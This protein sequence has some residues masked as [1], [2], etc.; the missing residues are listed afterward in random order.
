M[1][2]TQV[3]SGSVVLLAILGLAAWAGET[4]PLP[5]P[6][7]AP[8][9]G[10]V[11]RENYYDAKRFRPRL[12]VERA[13]R[14]LEQSEV[15]VDTTWAGDQIVLNLRGNRRSVPAA[16]PGTD[17]AAAMR[18]IESVRLAV[19]AGLDVPPKRLRELAYTLANGALSTLDPHTV[20]WPP[21]AAREWSED[22][23]Q[24]QFYGIGAFLNQEEG[25]IS[26]Q[27]VMAGLPAE[28]AGV[29]DGD[30]ILAIDGEKT[31][32]LTLEQ[33]VR[34]I[35]GPKGTTVNL[36]L[37]RKGVKAPVELPI[38]RDLVKVI[39]M[40]GCRD[41]GVGYVRMDEFNANT[42]HD[43]FRTLRELEQ[44]ASGAEPA[45]PLKALVL[46]LRFN[47]GGLL[48]QAKLIGGFFLGRGQEIVRTTTVDGEEEKFTNSARRFVVAPVMVLTSAGT[49]S[50][51]EIVSG[52]LQRNERAVIAGEPT[53]GKGSVQN[54]RELRDASRLKL[55]IQEYLL[56]GGVS[57]QDVGV[58]PDL[59]LPRHGVRQDGSVDLREFAYERER[60]NEFALGGRNTYRHEASAELGWLD[61]WLDREARRKHTISAREFVP[62][63][64]AQLAIDLLK[65][66]SAAEDWTAA[67]AKALD[68][69][70]QRAFLL[71][72]LK[73]PV[74]RRA[75]VEASALA[76]TLARLPKPVRWGQ[77]ATPSAGQMGIAWTGPAEVA[78]G[79]TVAL[80]VQVDNHGAQDAGRM[81]AIIRADPRSPFWEEEL[82]V[83]AV[84]AG[85]SATGLLHF[86]V[87]PRLAE[88]E[89]RFSVDLMVDGGKQAVASCD[90]RLRIKA[91]PAPQLGL[92]WR[93]DEPSGDLKLALDE[94]AELKVEVFNAGEGIAD[95]AVLWVE[96]NN[97]PYIALELSRA[98]I[99]QPI[100]PG[101]AA[102]ITVPF[103]V[104]KEL[105]RAGK[106]AP[107]AADRIKLQLNAA[108]T[109]ADGIDGRFR[110]SIQ[111]EVEIPIG[112]LLKPRRVQ[113]VAI[114]FQGSE[115]DGA[116]TRLHFG[117][118]D[119]VDDPQSEAVR[120][121]ALFQ[122]EDKIDLQLAAALDAPADQAK[123]GPWG[124]SP[125]V[126]L[127]P[128][129]NRFRLLVSDGDGILSDRHIRLWGPPAADP[130]VKPNAAPVPAPVP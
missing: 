31:A 93:V 108:E 101:G 1:R 117:L 130:G 9:I 17:M 30:V 97:D 19:E 89:E 5:F 54:I 75:E 95:A 113:P 128:G 22:N 52:A 116:R 114:S 98:K 47:G 43:L 16:D 64:E 86:K 74:A 85:G 4:D 37:E 115:P 11:L 24:G 28:R 60:D 6:D 15:G 66:A 92:A 32:G 20:L 106:P 45:G 27:R 77:L 12:M 44:Q 34:R 118:S 58:M 87:P 33:A 41:G 55:T 48:D 111:A 13:L 3:R 100:K 26:I 61:P 84:P 49:A 126:T 120:F 96:K 57:I 35:K 83:G 56:P 79:E 50:A 104:R 29:E 14:F 59:L 67:A 69:D 90:V 107:F 8:A 80:T 124:Y 122:D 51:A 10:E 53:F 68:A 129:L 91:R 36:A 72:R 125:R 42:A 7:M 73:G 99:E 18:I 123:A 76:D 121:V 46:D 39:T 88:G 102:T 25:L 40:R 110:S 105:K 119:Q 62:D 127:K 2:L 23:I 112:Q 21:E 63:R 109:F 103:T 65:E 71:E 38:V 70:S 82:I 81:F 78:A 94:R